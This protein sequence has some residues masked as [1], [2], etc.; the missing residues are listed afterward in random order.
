[1]CFETSN[2]KPQTRKKIKQTHILLSFFYQ[3]EK[4]EC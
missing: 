4:H 1:M 2:K 3:I